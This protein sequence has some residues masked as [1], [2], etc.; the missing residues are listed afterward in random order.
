M[1]INVKMSTVGILTF[2]SMIHTFDESLKAKNTYF[3]AFSFYG[4]LKFNA[5]LS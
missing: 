1:L 2:M 5:Q 4:H 3:S